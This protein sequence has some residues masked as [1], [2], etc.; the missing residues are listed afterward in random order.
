V[1]CFVN[2]VIFYSEVSDINLANSAAEK[3]AANMNHNICLVWVH[4]AHTVYSR[5]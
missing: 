1:Q 5:I 2:M 4:F 3:P